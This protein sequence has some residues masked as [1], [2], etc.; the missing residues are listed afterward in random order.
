MRTFKANNYQQALSQLQQI[1]PSLGPKLKEDIDWEN[2]KHYAVLL[3]KRINDTRRERY[4]T[5]FTVQMFNSRQWEKLQKG[6]SYL[7]YSTLILLHDPTRKEAD[8]QEPGVTAEAQDPNVGQGKEIASADP[9]FNY[10]SAKKADLHAFM[11]KEGISYGKDETNNVLR[12][13]IEKFLLNEV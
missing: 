7:G 13:R 11:D 10:K 3:I 5:S 8:I 6:F 2:R 1:D 12:N 4:L 9:G